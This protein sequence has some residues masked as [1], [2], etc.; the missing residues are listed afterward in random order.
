MYMYISY[1]WMLFDVYT[2]QIISVFFSCITLS[3]REQA[4]EKV[5]CVFR[6]GESGQMLGCDNEEVNVQSL[7]NVCIS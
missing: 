3:Y 1:H 7:W 5:F 2:T 6:K 4:R